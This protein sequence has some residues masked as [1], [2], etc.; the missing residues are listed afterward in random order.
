MRV[1]TRQSNLKLLLKSASEIVK[2]LKKSVDEP[3]GS[4]ESKSVLNKTTTHISEYE[5]MLYMYHVAKKLHKETVSPNSYNN[6]L[7]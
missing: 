6:C 1:I 7:E 5:Y 4:Q 2:I 3:Q